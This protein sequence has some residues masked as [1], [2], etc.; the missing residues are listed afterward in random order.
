MAITGT[1]LE[2]VADDYSYA[3]GD[4]IK[5][6]IE[7]INRLDFPIELVGLTFEPWGL[8][9]ELHQTMQFNQKIVNDYS[10]NIPDSI[11]LTSPYWLNEKSTLGMYYVADKEKIGKAINDPILHARFT[12]Y[13]KS[14][15]G[16]EKTNLSQVYGSCGR[17]SLSTYCHRTRYG[18]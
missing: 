2:V 5:L 16:I 1:Y 10:L 9:I 18:N 14:I 3:R 11:S 4:R 6:S 8:S 15:F 17:R 13:R 12:L 7:A